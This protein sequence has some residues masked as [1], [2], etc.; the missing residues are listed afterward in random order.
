MSLV[1]LTLVVQAL[2]FFVAYLILKYLLLKPAVQAIA[3]EDA[4][5]QQLVCLVQESHVRIQEKKQEIQQRWRDCQQEFVQ[6]APA[7]ADDEFALRFPV[8][9]LSLE[10]IHEEKVVQRSRELQN[11][12]IKKVGHVRH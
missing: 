7:I 2:N 4:H 9:V 5:Q 11:E 6:N 8:R 3:A 12:L 1:N 10:P